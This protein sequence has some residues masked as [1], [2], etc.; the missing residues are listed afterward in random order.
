M[1]KF[2]SVMLVKIIINVITLPTTLLVTLK[3]KKPK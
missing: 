2:L 1:K 3:A